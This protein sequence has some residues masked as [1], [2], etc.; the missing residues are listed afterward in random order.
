MRSGALLAPL[1][2]LLASTSAF[3]QPGAGAYGPSCTAD[4]AT[5]RA[6]KMLLPPH[7]VVQVTV[8][9]QVQCPSTGW[10]VGLVEAVP[11]GFNPA[12][13]ILDLVARKPPVSAPKVTRVKVRF[14][15]NVAK[16]IEQVTI[17]GGGPDFTIPFAGFSR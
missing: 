12:I 7:P 11:Q 2:A 16:T 6:S 3:A 9:G 13:L 15:K 14:Q 5:F 4:Q 8:V 10:K 17:R 1:L